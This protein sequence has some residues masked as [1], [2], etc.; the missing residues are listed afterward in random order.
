MIVHEK[1][2]TEGMRARWAAAST[3]DALIPV[4]RVYA[5][6]IAEK[7]AWP[8]AA[9]KVEEGAITRCGSGKYIREFTAEV[10]AETIAANGDDD[11][12][13]AALSAAF[14]GDD[15]DP[16]AGLV[17]PGASVM[18]SIEE[19]GGGVRPTQFRQNGSDFLRLTSRF[20][21]MVHGEF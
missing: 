6:R 1:D 8:A 13:R 2:I 11:A 5:D 20:A 4:E 15:T 7:T 17:V 14:G 9:I 12:I 21:I 10:M 3:L 18:H 16:T 19:Q